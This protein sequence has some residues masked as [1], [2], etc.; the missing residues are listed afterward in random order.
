MGHAGAIISGGKGTASEKMAAMKKAGIKVVED[1]SAIG[2][3][4]LNALGKKKSGSNK[5]KSQKSKTKSKI[6]KSKKKR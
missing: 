2:T 3:T 4:M 1:P 6:K 5:V